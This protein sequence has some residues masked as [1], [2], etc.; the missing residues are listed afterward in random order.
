MKKFMHKE[1][2]K[3]V[4]RNELFEAIVHLHRNVNIQF[5][6]Q[7]KTVGRLQNL[8]LSNPSEQ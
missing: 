8:A 1:G 5:Q 3:D 2:R 7:R 4:E 6:H